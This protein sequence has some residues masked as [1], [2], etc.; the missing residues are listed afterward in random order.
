LKKRVADLNLSLRNAE[1]EGD[2]ETAAKYA[3]ELYS[4]KMDLSALDAED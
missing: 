4:L 2:V 3:Q 1:S